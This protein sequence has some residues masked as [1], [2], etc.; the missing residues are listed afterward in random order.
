MQ[1]VLEARRGETAAPKT[2]PYVAATGYQLASVRQKEGW[3]RGKVKGEKKA[4]GRG[5]GRSAARL[6]GKG[7]EAA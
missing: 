3:R 6:P 7:G 5:G 1:K 4:L 2:H